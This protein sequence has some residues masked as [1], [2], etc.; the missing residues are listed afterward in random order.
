[1][2]ISNKT[3][4]VVIAI[5]FILLGIGLGRMFTPTKTIEIPVEN[6]Y[7]RIDDS[8]INIIKEDSAIIYVLYIRIRNADSLN[9]LQTINHKADVKQ[10][11][12]FNNITRLNYLDSMFRSERLGN[13]P[14][15]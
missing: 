9:D 4:L 13:L 10:V 8:L 11:K 6:K 7:K 14:V 3:W 15:Q 5:G 2:K 1:M 12:K